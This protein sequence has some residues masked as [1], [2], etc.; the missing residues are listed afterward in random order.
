MARL[1]KPVLG[2]LNGKAGNI[3]GRD[4][5]YDHYI[6]VRPKKYKVKKKLKEVSSKQRFQTAG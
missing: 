5:G 1:K 4:F 2:Q 6:S 3:V